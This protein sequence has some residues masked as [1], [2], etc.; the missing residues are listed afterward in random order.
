MRRL[1]WIWPILW[2]FLWAV[3]FFGLQNSFFPAIGL[4][5]TVP[6]LVIVLIVTVSLSRGLYWSLP[7]AL[8]LGV[9]TDGLFG[10]CLGKYMFCY[11]IIAGFCS[12][13]GLRR[14]A[15]RLWTAPIL[16]A[17]G[18]PFLRLISFL[19]VYISRVSV[20]VSA[21]YLFEL[22]ITVLLTAFCSVWFHLFMYRR[23]E[24]TSE[25]M[26]YKRNK[27]IK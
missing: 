22:A 26:R 23:L 5:D 17:A 20:T 19:I 3:L 9:L 21:R 6:E 7:L 4:K 12:L 8:I 15:D 1:R 18:V 25:D 2:I 11:S 27:P 14:Y 10:D 24:Q 13:D 16:S